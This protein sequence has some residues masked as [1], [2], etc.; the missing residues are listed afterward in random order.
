MYLVVLLFSD[1]MGVASIVMTAACSLAITTLSP[2]HKTE[3][4]NDI[5]AVLQTVQKSLIFFKK[6]IPQYANDFREYVACY[7]LLS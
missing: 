2:R 4:R 5:H 1:K 3:R 7:M 6:Q